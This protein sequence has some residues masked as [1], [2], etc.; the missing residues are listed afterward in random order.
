MPR[1][2]L[3]IFLLLLVL[4]P[5]VRAQGDVVLLTIGDDAVS[6]R[7]FE[8]HFS[9]SPEKRADVFAETYGRFK[10]KVQCARAL[11]LD[12]L[13]TFRQQM[14]KFRERAEQ[15][16]EI[17]ADSPL[18]RTEEREWIKLEILTW[19]LRQSDG[20]EKQRE[21]MR[22]M[23]SL[24]AALQNG[25]DVQAEELPWMQT[26]HLLAE[27]QKQLD[28][29]PQNEFSRPF[30]SPMGIHLIAWKEK[31]SGRTSGEAVTDTD[32]FFR[33][34][35]ME[36]A[37][38]ALALERSLDERLVCTEQGL[39]EFFKQHHARYGHGKPHFKGAVVHC[40]DKK[41]AKTIKKY[42]KKY[43]ESL[44][45]EAVERMPDGM[46]GG[47]RLETGLFAIGTN[48]YVDKLVFKCGDFNPPDDYPYTWV[49]GKKLKKGPADY[50]DVRDRLEKDFRA[51]RKMTEME[52][53]MSKYGVEINKEVLKTVNRAGNK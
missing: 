41:A 45:K 46:A 29:L 1:R 50:K 14:K 38:L 26:R 2:L 13:A 22:K 10:Q 48:P 39:E 44:W 49:L 32:R 40:R 43:P 21:G 53:L 24:Y 37:L 20:K 35:G 30:F 33:Q 7:E 23:D 27:W 11:G 17:L 16:K 19:P 42:L 28:V 9:R 25:A 4:V 8:Y 31:M 6:L 52:A 47:C 51:A 36:D 34:R 15:K 12:T 18:S 5:V 3:G